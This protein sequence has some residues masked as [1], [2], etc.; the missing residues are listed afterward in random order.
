M[1]KQNDIE[2]IMGK[3]EDGLISA[4][5]ANVQMVRLEGVRLV[6]KLHADVRRALN[7]AVK[8]GRLC[9]LR[10]DG[11][12]PEAYFHPNSKGAAIAAR[13]NNANKSIAAING[14]LA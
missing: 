11:L 2:T 9:H 4:A 14:V 3:L 5:Q 1:S 6:T 13:N 10:K 7:S 12:R 8:D